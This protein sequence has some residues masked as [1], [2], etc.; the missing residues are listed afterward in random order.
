[1]KFGVV[2]FTDPREVA[3]SDERERYNM[4]KHI[5]FVNFIRKFCKIVDGNQVLQKKEKNFGI[6][7]MEEVFAVERVFKKEDICGL[8][9]LLPTWTEPNLPLSLASRLN[10][11]VMLYSEDEGLWPGTTCMTSTGATFWQNSSSIYVLKHFRSMEKEK[12]IPWIRSVSALNKLKKSSL[13]LLGGSY[14]LSMEHLEEDVSCI[15]RLFV[16]D[17]IFESEYPIIQRAEDIL[18]NEEERV[19]A[20]LEWIKKNGCKIIYDEKMVTA[21]SLKKQS[22]I[23]L[24]VKDFVN[25]RDDIIGLSLK[26]QPDLSVHYGVTGCFVPAFM[27]FTADSEGKKRSIAAVCEG[28]IKGLLSSV[29]LETLAGIPALFGD[30]KYV[31]DGFMIIS[32]CGASSIYYASKSCDP[33]ETLKNV[34]LM[35]QCQG[36][37]GSAVHYTGFPSEVTVARFI[38]VEDTYFLQSAVGKIEKL[39]DELKK[40]IVW[41]SSWPIIPIRLSENIDRDLLINSFGS[42][43]YSAVYGNY[44]E[45]LSIVS[46][47]LGIRMVRMDR[48]SSIIQFLNEV[49]G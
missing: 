19:N 26:C 49:Y 23:Y 35:A 37:S 7:N 18:N 6:S 34:K 31:D 24:A 29:L 9:I 47:L 2:T 48:E 38:R 8:F 30:L 28:D 44:I 43:H 20:F 12:V 3:L 22:A 46:K 5:E 13:L 40:K 45:E 42:N 16:N 27:P 32:N 21:D 25:S 33:S 41:G 39:S 36:A 14:S 15:K 1:M 11:P 17:V 4:K 10:V